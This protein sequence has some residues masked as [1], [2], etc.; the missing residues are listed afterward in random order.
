MQGVAAHQGARRVKVRE[1]AC[2]VFVDGRVG[3]AADVD[4][5]EVG[6]RQGEDVAAGLDGGVLRHRRDEVGVAE[7]ERARAGGEGIQQA[8]L[9][10][11]VPVSGGEKEVAVGAFVKVRV[12]LVQVAHAARVQ[13]FLAVLE[14][15]ESPE[16]VAWVG[17][18][19]VQHGV[20][21]GDD[22]VR[23]EVKAQS[24]EARDHV[25][26]ADAG[27]V[28]ED[29]HLFAAL[30]QGGD[31]FHRAGDGLRPDVQHAKGV[32]PIDVVSVGEGEDVFRQLRRARVRSVLRQ[33]VADGL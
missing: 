32:E 1:A 5:R 18:E 24:G 9:A 16:G 22:F 13:V 3:F 26:F 12:V 21:A 11:V 30:A 15:D 23:A 19:R 25:R 20:A 33:A 17:G 10:R 27:G 6:V 14:T 29:K 31:R 2:G 8:L 4:V 28:G 7:D